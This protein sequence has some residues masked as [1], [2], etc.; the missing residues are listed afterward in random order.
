[1]ADIKFTHFKDINNDFAS[2]SERKQYE[3]EISELEHDLEV[4][5]A[6][7]DHINFEKIL[8]LGKIN[9]LNKL[10]HDNSHEM[11]TKFIIKLNK[12]MEANLNAIAY[13]DDYFDK[14]FTE[15]A[16]LEDIYR[17]KI[18]KYYEDSKIEE[19]LSAKLLI[20]KDDVD[21]KHS[22]IKNAKKHLAEF[23]EKYT[24][25]SILRK[26]NEGLKFLL[27]IECE[28][29]VMMKS[30]KYYPSNNIL[31]IK[32]RSS[33]TDIGKLVE[34]IYETPYMKYKNILLKQYGIKDWDEYL[35]YARKISRLDISFCGVKGNRYTNC[36]DSF[37]Q[38]Y[39]TEDPND[40][41]GRQLW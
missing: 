17:T 6:K 23:R 27:I 25:T 12:L 29:N 41:N 24:K 5:D 14:K 31:N 33:N 35:N 9:K 8:I 2:T 15:H 18:E 34:E 21:V 26:L 16:R 40:P 39:L 3:N 20:D 11:G 22:Y 4:Y 32:H 37:M 7:I 28:L 1:M 13:S 36:E 10:T 30:N 19:D 38:Y